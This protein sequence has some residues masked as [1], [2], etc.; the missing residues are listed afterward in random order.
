[1]SAYSWHFSYSRPII[2][3]IGRV[4]YIVASK[5]WGIISAERIWNAT[6]Q[7]K[8]GKRNRLVNGHMG[9][10]TVVYGK[11]QQQKSVLRAT[12]FDLAGRLWN[13]DD[14]KCCNMDEKFQ[15]LLDALESMKTCDDNKE[16]FFNDWKESWETYTLK[17]EG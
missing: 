12:A 13:D 15:P 5:V 1:M 10:Q 3:I 9:N 14:F 16:S 7:M 8:D 11:Y 17:P 2:D 4:G 6:K